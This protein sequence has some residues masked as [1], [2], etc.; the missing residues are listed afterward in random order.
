MSVAPSCCPSSTAKEKSADLKHRPKCLKA[1]CYETTNIVLGRYK[2]FWGLL[3]DQLIQVLKEPQFQHFYSVNLWA[4]PFS[5]VLFVN[6]APVLSVY[7]SPGVLSVHAACLQFLPPPPGW[8]P[9]EGRLSY[10][11]HPKEPCQLYLLG[12]VRW[13]GWPQ[14]ELPESIRSLTLKQSSKS[15]GSIKNICSKKQLKFNKPFFDKNLLEKK[16]KNHTS[17]YHTSRENFNCH[18]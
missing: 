6:V 13:W 15:W 7:L 5:L 17:S 12:A 1:P 2:N 14:N 10:L 3:S 16:K 18:K 11:E 8:D 4:K 9:H